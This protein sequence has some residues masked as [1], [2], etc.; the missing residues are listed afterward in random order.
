MYNFFIWKFDL[1]GSFDLFVT[2]RSIHFNNR[3]P[4]LSA[5][6]IRK[7]LSLVLRRNVLVPWHTQSNVWTLR[8]T[9]EFS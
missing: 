6:I 5:L 4:D 7:I 1:F 9:P 2:H 3:A 8:N